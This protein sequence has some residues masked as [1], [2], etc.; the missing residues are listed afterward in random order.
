MQIFLGFICPSYKISHL[1]FPPFFPV[2][3]EGNGILFVMLTAPKI[4]TATSVPINIT[5][6]TVI[7]TIIK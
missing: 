2:G 1:I 3:R 5:P 4:T 6:V 7:I